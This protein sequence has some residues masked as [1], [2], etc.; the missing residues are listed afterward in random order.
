[1]KIYG[2]R[3]F[4]RVC[5]CGRAVL[6]LPVGRARARGE[7]EPR[8]VKNSWTVAEPA[9]GRHASRC[10]PE[11]P[12]IRVTVRSAG[13][14]NVRLARSSECSLYNATRVHERFSQTHRRT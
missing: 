10:Q 13:R 2:V 5:F 9:V 14:S 1:M 6:T 3:N 7:G 8:G 12:S 4:K 11:V